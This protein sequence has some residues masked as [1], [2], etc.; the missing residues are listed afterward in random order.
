VKTSRK[1]RPVNIPAKGGGRHTGRC[2]GHRPASPQPRWQVIRRALHPCGCSQPTAALARPRRGDSRKAD[3]VA[4]RTARSGAAVADLLRVKQPRIGGYRSPSG[5]QRK[6]QSVA[7][8]ERRFAP[9]LPNLRCLSM[10]SSPRS[11]S[12]ERRSSGRPRALDTEG[13]AAA[14]DQW[15]PDVV[16]DPLSVCVGWRAYSVGARQRSCVS[17]NPPAASQAHVIEDR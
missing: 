8:R 10:A 1:T 17:G 2:R 16:A 3:A 5:G 9:G 6:L 7:D 12:T 4:Y 14:R 15:L 13:L 11:S